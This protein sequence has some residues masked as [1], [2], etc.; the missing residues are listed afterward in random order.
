MPEQ[1]KYS[2]N[3]IHN[4]C[5]MIFPQGCQ[6]CENYDYC[7]GYS[8]GERDALKSTE[9]SSGNTSKP[10]KP[11]LARFIKPTVEQVQEYAD[12]IGFPLKAQEFVDYYET[13]GWKVGRNPMKNWQAAVRTWF[14]K[15]KDRNPDFVP[16][17]E[18]TED[19]AK[20][21]FKDFEE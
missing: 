13:V 3:G 12:N 15:F 11:S 21:L 7:L 14:T 9:K 16:A 4:D 17:L 5:G 6:G 10:K 19:E 18:T 2:R 20:D 8:H 1:G